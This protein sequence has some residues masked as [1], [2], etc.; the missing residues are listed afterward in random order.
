MKNILHIHRLKELKSD[1]FLRFEA[2]VK[3]PYFH[4]SDNAIQLIDLI[5]PYHPEFNFPS[6]VLH[7]IKNLSPSKSAYHVLLS[8]MNDLLDEFELHELFNKKTFLKQSLN[9]ELEL[10]EKNNVKYYHSLQQISEETI[11]SSDD[12]YA[13]FYK[14]F[15]SIALCENNWITDKEKIFLHSDKAMKNLLNFFLSKYLMVYAN[16]ITHTTNLTENQEEPPET[17]M[18]LNF[19]KEHI[20]EQPLAV[21]CVYYVIQLYKNI[22]DNTL[23]DLFYEKIKKDTFLL[24]KK[25]IS[26]EIKYALLQTSSASVIKCYTEPAYFKNAFEIVQFLLE[27]ELYFLDQHDLIIQQ[28]FILIVKIAL[29]ANQKEWAK[30]FI[31]NEIGR[32]KKT[33]QNNFYNYALGLVYFQQQEYNEAVRLM[34]KINLNTPQFIIDYK[35]TLLKM[36][37]ELDDQPGFTYQSQ[38]F[39]KFLAK[40]KLLNKNHKKNM[41][42]SAKFIKLLFR[43]KKNKKYEELSKKIES[44]NINYLI[45]NYRDKWFAEKYNQLTKNKVKN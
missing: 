8:R 36:Y 7:K 41:S 11:F 9:Y 15:A 2:F 30:N 1:V 39:E 19:L 24:Q 27:K 32:I 38:T 12:L 43:Y 3:S 40:D 4:K 45:I 28:R 35:I 14:E 22:H 21:K 31:K 18:V 44:Q 17:T 29:G 23:F 6:D 33:S 42:D 34:V 26:Y 10:E 25:E 20:N 37:F 16:K 13:G 5:K